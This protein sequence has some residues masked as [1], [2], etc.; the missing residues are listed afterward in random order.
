[1]DENKRLVYRIILFAVILILSI[2]AFFLGIQYLGRAAQKKADIIVN[3]GKITGPLYYN[4][5]AIAQGGEEQG[6]RMF[7][8]VTAQLRELA[9]RYIRIDHIYD[10][11]NVVNRDGNGRIVMNFAD[12]DK[13]VCDIYLTG[14]KPFFA[15]GY[16]PPVLS[17]DGTLVGTP[18]NWDEWSFVVQ[19][20]I[21]RYSGKNTA[22]WCGM[23]GEKL[24]GIYYEV[25]NE[26]DLFGRW[27]LYSNTKNYKTLYEYSAKGAKNAQNTQ[28]FSL[29]GPGTTGAY[30]NWFQLFLTWAAQNNIR[31]D[32][33]SWHHYTQDPDDYIDDVKNIDSWI[34]RES[35]GKFSALPKM[36]TEWGYDSEPNQIADTNVGA[37]YT[38][39]SVRNLIDQ[40]VKYAF[41]FDAKDGPAPRWGI[42]THTG[43]KKPRF[44]ALKFM[45][46]LDGNRLKVDG[47]GTFVRA[48]A[49]TSPA[50]T[51]TIL[52]N[53]DQE[54]KNTE[55]VPVRFTNLVPGTYRLDITYLGGV[56][57]LE[58]NIVPRGG[59]YKRSVL[60]TPNQVA[61]LVLTKK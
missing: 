52:V 35:Y 38:I 55:L 50:K 3:T 61:A 11:Y 30:K 31:I 53:Y 46:L 39:A 25:W 14:A 37:A 54:G 56:K 21:E 47:E 57:S 15:L 16:M 2:P 58:D 42:L 13:T 43:E 5:Q 33:I 32:F 18:T 41:T 22:L 60:L 45:N 51:V 23:R 20:T 10:F 44:E 40:K 8:N 27:D 17:A 59:F 24:A 1:M 34:P 28:R 19:K 36:I 29:G 26:P 4:W 7:Q 6:V 48:I 49:S 12:L 9:P